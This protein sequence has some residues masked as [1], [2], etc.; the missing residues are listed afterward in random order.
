MLLTQ[1]VNDVARLL[2][3]LNAE[4]Q[5]LAQQRVVDVARADAREVR[6]GDAQGKVPGGSQRAFKQIR[7]QCRRLSRVRGSVM[8]EAS[9]FCQLA[10]STRT[11][12]ACII[13]VFRAWVSGCPTECPATLCGA[14]RSDH[15]F[16]ESGNLY[17]QLFY[18]EFKPGL[19]VM[20]DGD[21][22]SI[23][24]NEYVKP[25]KARRLTALRSVT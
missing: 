22:C 15:P 6:L 7:V 24:E 11:A 16:N 5:H 25:A 9:R 1:G 4:R 10:G 19:K 14:A 13:G 3:E 23:L 20:L 12:E 21:P 2:I 18:N 17:G 8:L